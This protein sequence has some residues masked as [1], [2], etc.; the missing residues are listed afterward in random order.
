MTLL[1]AALAVVASLIVTLGATQAAYFQL[2]DDWR[3]YLRFVLMV[4]V[5]CA[6]LALPVLFLKGVF[7]AMIGALDDWMGLHAVSER[8]FYRFV[9]RMIW[10]AGVGARA[11]EGESR[12][13]RGVEWVV[14]WF[15]LPLGV[16]LMR[17]PFWL[18]AGLGVALFCWL[19]Y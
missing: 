3:E 10:A 11:P 6:Y 15:Y 8:S 2:L 1:A 4:T 17:M 12:A 5:L 13:V 14:E 16:L 9:R 7:R 18:L 19:A